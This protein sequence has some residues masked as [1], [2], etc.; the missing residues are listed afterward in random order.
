MTK[1][2]I[3]AVQNLKDRLPTQKLVLIMFFSTP[4]FRFKKLEGKN[5]RSFLRQILQN[6]LGP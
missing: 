1:F 3:T 5:I 6:I 4:Q 2:G